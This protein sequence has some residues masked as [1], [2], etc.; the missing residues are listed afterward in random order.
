[1]FVSDDMRDINAVNRNQF[2]SLLN[3]LFRLYRLSLQMTVIDLRYYANEDNIQVLIDILNCVHRIK[4]EYE[5]KDIPLGFNLL[6]H[7]N[8]IYT[9]HL[10][11][12]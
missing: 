8:R 4:I 6:K 3:D 5:R 10:S 9:V 1:M 12:Y 7:G 11:M 2:S